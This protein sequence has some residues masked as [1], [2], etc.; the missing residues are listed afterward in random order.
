MKPLPEF[1][2]RPRER[3]QRFAQDVLTDYQDPPVSHFRELVSY[4][5]G[6]FRVMFDPGYFVLLAEQAAPSKSQ[7]NNLKKKFKRHDPLVFIF[8]DHGEVT[9]GEAKATCFYID[10]GFLAAAR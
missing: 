2:P 1:R 9:C 8:K 3:V 10:F 4:P 5:D 6:H 7:W